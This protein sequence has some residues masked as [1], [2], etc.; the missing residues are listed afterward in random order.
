MAGLRLGS[1]CPPGT[2][3][4]RYLPNAP[5]RRFDLLPSGARKSVGGNLYRNV[6][7]TVSEYFDRFPQILDDA[8]LYETLRRNL[9][10]A[11]KSAIVSTLTTAVLRSEYVVKPRSIGIPLMRR[12]WPPSKP[13][14][15]APAAAGV[16]PLDS[17]TGVGA[18]AAAVSTA[19]APSF[20]LCALRGRSSCCGMVLNSVLNSEKCSLGDFLYFDQMAHFEDHSRMAGVS[21]VLDGSIEP[22]QTQGRDRASLVLRVAD[23]ALLPGYCYF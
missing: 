15:T 17:T 2:G 13:G 11:G 19:L 9:V 3:A 8:C 22:A 10:A 16:L 23:V 5:A 20:L 1:L 7:V 14:R 4:L 21:L 18:P 6:D 12:C